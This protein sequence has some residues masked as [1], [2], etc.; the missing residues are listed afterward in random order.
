M[1]VETASYSTAIAPIVVVIGALLL[2]WWMGQRSEKVANVAVGV[3]LGAVVVVARKAKDIGDRL[4]EIAGHIA[5]ETLAGMGH[6]DTQSPMR[7]SAWS[8]WFTRTHGARSPGDDEAGFGLAACGSGRMRSLH[9]DA[10][11]FSFAAR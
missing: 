7:R 2:G 10:P 6:C 3:S 8:V 1:L 9:V 4:R 5:S 11:A